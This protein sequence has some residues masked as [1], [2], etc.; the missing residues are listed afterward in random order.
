MRRLRQDRPATK[1]G[2]SPAAL[3][4]SRPTA[5]LRRALASFLSVHPK[6]TRRLSRRP[7]APRHPTAAPSGPAQRPAL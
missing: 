7:S 4:V 6:R 1:K 2:G 5:R 3:F